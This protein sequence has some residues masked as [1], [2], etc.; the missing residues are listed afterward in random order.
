M[1][2]LIIRLFNIIVHYMNELA[3]RALWFSEHSLFHVKCSN[4]FDCLIKEMF[5]I[6]QPKQ[7][8]KV[9][10]DSVFGSK[11]IEFNSMQ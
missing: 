4:M 11:P 8:L 2:D 6:R 1:Y 10:A 9:Q 7:L 3:I 5:F